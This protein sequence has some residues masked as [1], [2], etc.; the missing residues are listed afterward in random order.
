M[1]L[2]EAARRMEELRARMNELVRTDRKRGVT[3]IAVFGVVVVG[4]MGVFALFDMNVPRASADDVTTSITVLNTAPTW[5]VNAEESAESSTTTPTNSGQT[6]TWDA[7]ATD[8]SGDQ[9]Y[10]IICKTEDTPTANASAPPSCGGGIANRWA[11]SAATNSG[12]EATAATTTKET[13]PFQNEKN[14]WYAWICDANAALPKCNTIVGRGSGT[15]ASPFVVNHPPIFTNIV[16]DGPEDPGGTVTWTA[17]A[18][19]TD[20]LDTTDTVRLFVCKGNDFTGT[21]CGAAGGWATSTLVASDPATTTSI[22]IPSQD[23]LYNAFVYVVDNHNHQATSS[24]QSFNSSFTVNNVAPT[25]SAATINLEDIDGSGNLTL[26]T[27]QA[28]SG[29]FKVR[30]TASD[31]NSCQNVATGNELTFVAANIYRSGVGTASCDQSGEYNANNCYVSASPFF[32]GMFSCQQ[33]GGSCSGSSDTSATW[34]CNFSLWYNA[35]PTDASTPWTAENWLA[36]VQISDDDFATSTL[37]EAT[38]GNEMTSFLAFNVSSTSIPYGSL[39]PG[40]QSA[41]LA[42]TTDLLA[43]G[44]VGLDE[45]LYGDTM[46]PTWSA[47]DSCDTNGFQAGND[48]LVAN[49]KV[50]TSSVTYADLEAYTLGSSTTPREMLIRVQKTTATTSPQTKGTYWGIAVPGTIT[51]AGAYTGQNTI[52]AKKSNSS[53]W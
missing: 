4:L 29:P 10:L 49:Q 33:D 8:S 44:N 23:G 9:Y 43:I 20:S 35:D 37:T 42:T 2:T 21:A 16:N 22:V 7:T 31:D 5:T 24:F 3:L 17:T 25:V 34:T 15:T 13:F 19:D 14:D 45:D 12:T 38:T 18:S 39:E 11:I 26:L 30:F 53:F 41:V 40:Q 6:V 48:I 36:S 32:S 47:P 46:C 51:T 27:P 52:T 28:T 1:S 50:A